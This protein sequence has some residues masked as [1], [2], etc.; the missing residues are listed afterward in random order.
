M[1][2]TSMEGKRIGYPNSMYQSLVMRDSPFHASETSVLVP[3][4]SKP[5]EFGKPQRFPM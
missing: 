3:P 4:M 2:S 1:V 5:I